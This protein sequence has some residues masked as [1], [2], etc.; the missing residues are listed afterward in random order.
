LSEETEMDETI[1]EFLVEAQENMEQGYKD[2]EALQAN[3]S[4][5]EP[6]RSL[7]RSIHSIKGASGFFN[8][9]TLEGVA[10]F[11]EDILSKVRD[12]KF[13][14]VPDRVALIYE[15]ADAI[16]KTLV[17]LVETGTEGDED[18]IELI[19][20]LRDDSEKPNDAEGGAPTSAEDKP[21]PEAAPASEA[22]NDAALEAA[23]EALSG[24]DGVDESDEADESVEEITEEV[25]SVASEVAPEPAPASPEP[26]AAA[27]PVAAAPVAEAAQASGS[28]A[29]ES[30]I[31]V[32]VSLL[33]GLMNLVEEL[34][35]S[36]NQILQFS[37]QISN[38]E[39]AN[40]CQA[41]NLI[42][43]E[44]QEGIMKTRMQPVSNVFSKF[45]RIVRDIARTCEKDI[46]F[47]TEGEET[48]LDRTI[49]EAIKD[50]LTHI[51]RN[52]V[53]H[54][55]E[56]PAD[57]IAAG[58]PETGTLLIRAKHEG[59]QVVIEI[60][61][62]GAG[63]NGQ[64]VRAK[65]I[66]KG[67]ITEAQ[68]AEMGHDELINLIFLP[69]F[70]TMEVVSN[71]SG[72]GVGMDVVRTNIE[73][74]GGVAELHS[75]EG[76]G[77]NLSIRIPL[78]LAIVPALIVRT[79]G[80]RFA[81][82]QVSLQELVRLEPEDLNAAIEHVAGAMT[83]RLRGKLLPLVRLSDVL[84]LE[85][86]VEE[87]GEEDSV[88][89][90]D[91]E[92]ENKNN[93]G[94]NILVLNAG[95]YQYGLLVEKVHDIEEVVVKP[96]SK[97]LSE[98]DAYAG[99]TILGDGK[100][101]LILDA[102]GLANQAEFKSGEKGKRSFAETEAAAETQVRPDAQSFLLFSVAPLEQFAIP[103]ALI[104][105]LEKFQAS[106]LS[107]AGGKEVIQY[108][109]HILPIIRFEDQLPIS[110]PEEQGEEINVIVFNFE[111]KEVGL[112][113][114]EIVDVI[115]TS[116]DLDNTTYNHPGIL[117]SSIVGERTTIF[118]DIFA[119]V[120]T[121]FPVW[122]ENKKQPMREGSLQDDSSEESTI[123][124]AEDSQFFRT[125][126]RSYLESNGFA[127]IEA[128]DGAEAFE[129]L[130]KTPGIDML[131]T[132]VEMPNMNGF[133]LAEKVR[134]SG[135]WND[136][137]IMALTSLAS[138]EDRER[139]LAAGVDEYCV[140]LERV[141]VLNKIKELVVSRTAVGATS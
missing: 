6:I 5:L 20:R 92:I 118:I 113:V 135:R 64:R 48:E 17:T 99:A 95:N 105:R 40:A 38:N 56:K 8:F 128:V 22:Q 134:A 12:G 107:I 71:L 139:G 117:G 140:K 104:S 112:M 94:A 43:G 80:E 30:S 1:R 15:G 138:D 41:F 63:I 124:L 111:G 75:E 32:D 60:I 76:K 122:F 137:P 131:V 26:V 136:L 119:V 2:L 98:V 35:L 47:K 23:N 89:N 7:F 108:R 24:I 90:L 27:A 44:L 100:V 115:D 77:T 51:V 58:K 62:D 53:D 4:N 59:G 79:C 42:T 49:I 133:E 29:A 123:L 83:Y 66:E 37:S 13:L 10:H 84:K 85:E 70:S 103:L 86:V 87:E 125:V 97:H 93:L 132:D 54:G 67:L 57:R 28:M 52:S 69:G 116:V 91:Q 72:R 88:Q 19:M 110:R 16:D 78:T 126:V 102:T 74:I 14:L 81:I 109:G 114:T 120:E 121:I 46:T 50:P 61:D 141:E 31:R 45:P 34:V 101:I 21:V 18:Y 82:P 127:V 73:R 25:P 11:C 55:I 106:E 68:A 130:E 33:E 96:L 9:S 39:L 129:I 36:R 3:P 65:A